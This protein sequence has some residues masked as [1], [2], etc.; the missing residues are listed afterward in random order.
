MLLPAAKV[1]ADDDADAV[2]RKMLA[3]SFQDQNQQ[4]EVSM[5]M[6]LQAKT[7]VDKE[8]YSSVGVLTIFVQKA[9]PFLENLLIFKNFRHF[10]NFLNF[11]ER[12]NYK[13]ELMNAHAAQVFSANLLLK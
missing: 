13:Q 5:H 9:C 11:A 12:L 4:A 7:Q 6:S 3:D 10:L 1:V 2:R 8:L